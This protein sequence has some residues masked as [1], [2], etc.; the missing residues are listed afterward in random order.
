MR[1]GHSGAL[2]NWCFWTVV[3]EHTLKNPLK[4]KEI[5]P[6]NLKGYQPWIIFGRTDAEGEATVLWLRG[7]QRMRWL[8]GITDSMDLNVC[9]LWEMVRNRETWNA[10]IH[11][12]VKTEHDLET[13]QQQLHLF[14]WRLCPP[15]SPYLSSIIVNSTSTGISHLTLRSLFRCP[16]FPSSSTIYCYYHFSDFHLQIL[17][18][19][20]S[21]IIKI[22]FPSTNILASISFA[23]ET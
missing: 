22:C 14:H 2:K 10:A 6:V 19:F 8:D 9:K 18:H 15:P 1:S 20:W 7:W 16:F 17:G 21:F 11:G 23:Q 4:S 5:K 3:L 13:K 12:V